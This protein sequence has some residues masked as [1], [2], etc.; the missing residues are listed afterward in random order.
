MH[1]IDNEGA[2]NDQALLV[3][4]RNISTSSW[5]GGL[6]TNRDS[7][8]AGDYN[9]VAGADAHFQFLRRLDFDAYLLGS[10]TPGRT[11]GNLAQRFQ[12]GW[13]DDELVATTEYSNVQPDFN[14]EVGFIRRR[15]MKN[16]TSELAWKQIGRAHV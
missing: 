12:A 13:V 5:I 4:K 11:G 10:Q 6:F 7:T 8:L 1:G 9:R 14:P 3:C 15:D 2:G 16:Y